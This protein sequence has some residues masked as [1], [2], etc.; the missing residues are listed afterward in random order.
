[1][2]SSIKLLI[3]VLFT[4]S[5]LFSQK[6]QNSENPYPKFVPYVV[7]QN[8][9]SEQQGNIDIK[10]LGKAQPA[11]WLSVDPMADKYPGWSP[12]NYAL[13]N[14]IRFLDPNGMWVASRDSS[15]NITATY[16]KGDT[17]EGLY[18]QLGMSTEQFAAWATSQGIQLSLDG[19]GMSFN[20][21]DFVLQQN[22]FSSENNMMNC[23][24]SSLYGAGAFSEEMP[25]Q[26]GFNFTQESQSVFGF[27]KNNQ[28]QIGSMITWQ[29]NS[30]T[31]QHSAIYVIKSQ[32]GTEYYVGRPG[33]N[34]DVIIQTSRNTSR[35]YPNYQ[36]TFLTYPFSKPIF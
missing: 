32:D 36:R 18:S 15:G 35:L 6:K 11:R 1:M 14:P 23:F 12:Y 16:E 17:Y 26:G 27:E 20:I 28:A 3:I 4:S 10:D 21:T 25:I 5:F 30:G 22:N 9:V 2:K 33:P 7:E 8:L 29:D 24:S 13:C 34:S 31:T 19:S